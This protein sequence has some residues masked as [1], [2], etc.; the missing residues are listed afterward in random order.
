MNT[1]RFRQ[2][3]DEKDI[4]HIAGVGNGDTGLLFI[5]EATLSG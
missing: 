3:V 5:S 2:A 1:Y 4:T